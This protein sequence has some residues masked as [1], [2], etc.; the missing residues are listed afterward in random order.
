MQLP[1]GTFLTLKK[2]VETSELIDGLKSEGFTGYISFL[3][4]AGVA[5]MIFDQGI[6]RYA[7]YGT[8]KGDEAVQKITSDEKKTVDAEIFTLTSVQIGLCIQFNPMY[9]VS[10]QKTMPAPGR[11][12]PASPPRPAP[13]TTTAQ[14]NQ[15]RHPPPDI[16]GTMQLP[17]GTFSGLK[18]GLVT[19]DLIEELRNSN[20]TG[21][22]AISLP[23]GKA[24]A[25][26]KEGILILAHLPPERGDN[27]VAN[28]ELAKDH[29][30]DAELYTL[31]ELQMKMVMEYNSAFAVSSRAD[32]VQPSLKMQKIPEKPQKTIPASPVEIEEQE[33][34]EPNELDEQIRALEDMDLDLMADRFR[35]NFK[36]V[37]KQMQ[38]HHLINENDEKEG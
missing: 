4:S 14:V 37:L 3:A 7:E 26:F 19:S 28:L 20:F 18:K 1:R 5:T 30:V 11:K 17:R 22:T 32:I 31:S 24:T 36:D 38:L 27:A 23:E 9:R 16:P 21:Y 33:E 10:E 35:D 34:E 12:S 29:P 6:L 2:Q 25:V 8:F 15:R 13:G